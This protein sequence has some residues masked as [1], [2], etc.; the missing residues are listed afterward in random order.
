MVS[1]SQDLAEFSIIILFFSI[2]FVSRFMVRRIVSKTEIQQENERREDNSQ[3]NLGEKMNTQITVSL[4]AMNILL[5]T[6]V[7]AY[8]LNVTTVR[9]F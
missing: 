8:Y 5:S 6:S 4:F 1:M 2:F 3:N 9:Y 7:T